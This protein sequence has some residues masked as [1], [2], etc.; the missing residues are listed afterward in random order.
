MLDY[1]QGQDQGRV[2]LGVEGRASTW[3]RSVLYIPKT[4]NF[5]TLKLTKI[6]NTL[7]F[8]NIQP[9]TSES[10]EDHPN[11][12]PLSKNGRFYRHFQVFPPTLLRGRWLSRRFYEPFCDF[13]PKS[14]VN[15]LTQPYSPS[16]TYLGELFPKAGKKIPFNTDFQTIFKLG[17][18]YLK[19]HPTQ[20]FT[21]KKSGENG[22]RQ[23]SFNFYVIGTYCDVINP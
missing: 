17:K 6:S 16:H 3:S 13:F 7:F 11:N 5:K 19:L 2:Q 8:S 18:K 12:T 4:V 15:H 10:V 20:I 9:T 23:R 22:G 21:P 1:D 14:T